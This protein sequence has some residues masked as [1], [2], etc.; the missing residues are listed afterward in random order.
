MWIKYAI[1]SYTVML[2]FDHYLFISNI[3]S[4]ISILW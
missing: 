1:A 2:Q 4:L 3:Y